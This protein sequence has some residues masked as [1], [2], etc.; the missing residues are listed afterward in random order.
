MKNFDAWLDIEL[1]HSKEMEEMATAGGFGLANADYWR[2]R[3]DMLEIMMLDS[4]A[5][6]M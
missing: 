1:A 6:G 5:W 4:L 2:G 3:R